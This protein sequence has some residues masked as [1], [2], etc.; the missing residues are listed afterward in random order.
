MAPELYAG[1]I[2][3]VPFVDV[4]NTMLDASL[5]LTPPEWL[6][7]GDP[8][9]RP[10]SLRGDPRLL[11]YDNV[12]PQ[13]YPAI[14]ALAGLTDPRVTY[15]EPAKW[16]ARLRAT[17]TGGGPVLLRTAMDAGHAGAPGR[18]DRLDDIARAYAFAIAVANGEIGANAIDWSRL[19]LICEYAARRCLPARRQLPGRASAVFL[20]LA[21]G[22]SS[23]SRAIC[24]R[25]RRG[26][27]PG[28]RS[29][30]SRRR[31]NSTD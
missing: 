12:R 26:R 2:A 28:R 19:E 27:S 16:V 4:L 6:E 5:P 21:F 15:W 8:I 18:F 23:I 10:R 1:I 31:A 24:V 13:R 20:Y 14:L 22:S 3:D 11:P 29:R 17:M 7:W 30:R 9:A 25:R